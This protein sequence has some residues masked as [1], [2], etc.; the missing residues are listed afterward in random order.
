MIDKEIIAELRRISAQLDP[1][2]YRQAALQS[3]LA[4]C[5]GAVASMNELELAKVTAQ[6]SN[7]EIN[8]LTSVLN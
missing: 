5:R 7:N 8:R 1:K 4:V 6:F 3:I 2:D